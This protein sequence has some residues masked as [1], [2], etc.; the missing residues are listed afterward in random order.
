MSCLSMHT[1]FLL[2]KLHLHPEIHPDDC[3]SLLNVA[4]KTTFSGYHYNTIVGDAL[5]LVL[6]FSLKD[7][8]ICRWF[9][10]KDPELLGHPGLTIGSGIFHIACDIRR[11]EHF[12]VVFWKENE[13]DIKAFMKK[14]FAYRKVII[15]ISEQD[16]ER[17]RNDVAISYP[18]WERLAECKTHKHMAMQRKCRF[19]CSPASHTCW[20]T[21]SFCE[22]C[23][24]DWQPL[25]NRQGRN[26]KKLWEYPQ[27]KTL[28]VNIKSLLDQGSSKFQTLRS[29]AGDCDFGRSHPPNG[30][31][32]GWCA[33]CESS[34]SS[35]SSSSSPSS[36]L[37]CLSS[38]SSSASTT[39]ASSSSSSSSSSSPKHPK[40]PHNFPTNFYRIFGSC[41]RIF[42]Q[43]PNII[44]LKRA[45]TDIRSLRF[46]RISLDTEN[47][48]Y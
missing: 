25:V 19:C 26:Q 15:P 7:K 42:R 4:Q 32:H 5:L 34:S 31:E 1:V 36:Q 3:K 10:D 43:S 38:S 27:C 44:W 47:N 18:A 45:E 16:L 41:Y 22:P 39:S 35:S 30:M 13:M 2:G 37:S 20:G 24:S 11:P 17:H 40:L 29:H 21:T 46:I 14:L 28:E 9:A 48:V 8:W 23:H 33:I 12:D 6:C